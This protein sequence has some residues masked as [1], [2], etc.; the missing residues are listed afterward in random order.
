VGSGLC[1]LEF[2]R[3]PS[4]FVGELLGLGEE[5]RGLKLPLT[6]EERALVDVAEI[7]AKDTIA[8]IAER[9]EREKSPLPAPVIAEWVGCGL[10]GMQV[11]PERGG[12]GASF[13]AKVAVAEAIARSCFPCAFAL[14]N[15]QGSV[16]RIEREGTAEQVER[17]LPNLMNGSLICAP[18]LSEPGAG[19]DFAAITTLATKVPGGWEIT[20]EKAWIT[21]GA[22][23][24]LLVM[25]AQTEPGSGGNGIASF[26]VDLEA[27]GIDKS[28]PYQLTG[29]AAIGAS[30]IRLNRVKV[31]D[32]DLFAPPGQAFKRA[33]KG[34]SGARTYV[35]AMT[36][37]VVER[38][39]RT[40][41]DY[42]V[43]RESF[44]RPLIDHQGLRWSLVDVATRLEAARLL[45][46]QAAH[47]VARDLD[48]QVEAALAKKFSAEIATQSVTACM[49]AMGAVG[50]FPQYGYDRLLTSARISAYVDGTTEMQNERIGAAL[51]KRYGRVPSFS[52]R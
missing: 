13:F 21:N 51:L 8:P 7:F 9:L 38:A 25:Y 5:T 34:I 30:A 37:A 18:S 15:M 46:L 20:G 40:A 48:A 50:L 28:P 41:V 19:S 33:L 14:I 22:I 6:R 24:K 42:A 39:L 3:V 17:Y 23:A 2:E 11:S 31:C 44:G 27:P 1:G 26:I 43:E 29:G 47:V 10:N 36:C 35:A 49:Q 12:A 16:T 32:R 4:N 52:S 45:T